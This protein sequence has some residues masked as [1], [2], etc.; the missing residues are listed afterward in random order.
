MKD[1]AMKIDAQIDI[2]ASYDDAIE[3]E[4]RDKASSTIFLIMTMTREQFINAAMNRLGCTD[5]KEA[6]VYHLDR[7][8]KKMEMGT[9]TFE[10]P[11]W[12]YTGNLPETIKLAYKNC[13]DGWIPD[14]SFSSQGSFY[15]GDD[16]KRYARTTI[17]KWSENE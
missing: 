1:K 13:P 6:E 14:T 8:G 15:T 4:V 12:G 17:R 3:I 2:R 7:V 16:G 9:L 10:I 11:D 5:V